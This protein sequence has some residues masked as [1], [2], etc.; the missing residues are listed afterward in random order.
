MSVITDLAD[1][2]WSAQFLGIPCKSLSETNPDFTIEDAYKVQQIN[3]NKRINEKGLFDSKA[4]L[5]GRKIG[6]TSKAVQ[7]WLEVYEPDFGALL[8]D[9]WVGTHSKADI[10][11]L[12]QPRVEGEIAFVLKK[13]ID[14]E[15]ITSAKI[16][17]AIDFALPAIEIIDSRIIDWKFKI[18]DTIADNA[19]CGMFVLGT[20]PIS[21]FD[22]DLRKIQ[23][24]L[25]K[26]EEL[27][28]EGNGAACM[29]NP[30]NAVVWLVKK[31]NE[32]GTQL[33]SGDIILSGAL[34]PVSPVV[35]G[36]YIRVQIGNVGEVAV[37]F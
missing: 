37:E 32:F 11:K 22:T 19:S 17:S 3:V 29:N 25:F 15:N 24:S 30:I 13:D 26:N 34:G 5:V 6:V 28:S 2:L 12:L 33:K 36:D 8:N 4:N 23:M 9:M 18:E 27:L 21:L 35:S 16:I 20:Q 7:D 14:G 31:L 10:T 1:R